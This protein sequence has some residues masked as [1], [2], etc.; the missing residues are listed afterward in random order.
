MA[1][2]WIST[3]AE[4]VVVSERVRLGN[5][6]VVLVSKIEDTFM[7]MDTMLAFIEDTPSRWFKAPVPRGT[8]VEVER[9]S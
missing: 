5:G 7:G 9:D 4:D 8:T 3:P 1:K 6:V 2:S